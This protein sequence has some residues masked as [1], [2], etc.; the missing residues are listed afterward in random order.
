MGAGWSEPPPPPPPPPLAAFWAALPAS[1][2][3][4]ACIVAGLF[5][6]L[7]AL[8]KL[9]CWNQARI[10][11]PKTHD[12]RKRRF[13]AR[14][15]K[16]FPPPYP[17]GWFHVCNSADIASGRVHSISA[18]GLD[19]VAFREKESGRVGVLSAFCPHLGAHLGEGGEV[20]GNSIRC[21]FHGWQFNAEGQA[22]K[23]PYTR[24]ETV[25]ARCKT[26][27]YE[28]RELVGTIWVWF[29]AEGRPPA[30][31]LH[32]FDD[33]VQ[34]EEGGGLRLVVAR[35]S[36]FEMHV[37]EMA[38]NSADPY[39]FQTLHSPLPIPGLEKI[40]GC[41]HVTRQVYPEASAE[42]AS[43][44]AARS[45]AK[46]ADLPNLLDPPPKHIAQF[47]E[48]MVDF[49]LGGAG[50]AN[51]GLSV[52]SWL[53]SM[54]V[55]LKA[56]APPSSSRRSPP[57]RGR[58]LGQLPRL[59]RKRTLDRLAAPPRQPSREAAGGSRCRARAPQPLDGARLERQCRAVAAAH[60]RG[61]DAA[62]LAAG[63]AAACA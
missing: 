20:V 19:L 4:I 44:P 60:A 29:D 50:S 32:E 47:W 26:T 10:K 63:P 37:C 5:I 46:R 33:V 59:G 52:V 40:V 62:A 45:A 31:E 28:V 43:E 35:S 15:R 13:R 54:S 36:E 39:H 25:P 12:P 57:S 9:H 14:R 24:L 7:R 16:E 8:G 22:V 30:Y 38:E 61:R 48:Q 17:N 1:L 51:G 34:Q 11:S 27:S 6:S 56:V 41:T 3:T 42:P 23:I 2:P 55:R 49:R 18:L 53:P 58:R 21:P